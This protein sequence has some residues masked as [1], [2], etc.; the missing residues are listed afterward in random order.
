MFH[1]FLFSVHVFINSFVFFYFHSVVGRKGKNRRVKSSFLTVVII[2]MS[3]IIIIIYS[4][5]F[6][7]S[8]SW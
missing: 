3:I 2:I 5:V 8:L 4:W 1:F 6:L 7:H